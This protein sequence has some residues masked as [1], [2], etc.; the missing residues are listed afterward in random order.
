MNEPLFIQH[1][2]M[3][4]GMRSSSFQGWTL[5]TTF[6]VF[7]TPEHLKSQN[8][9]FFLSSYFFLGIWWARGYVSIFYTSNVWLPASL[10][11]IKA[12]DK[13]EALPCH[14]TE[15]HKNHWNKK[16]DKDTDPGAGEGE[17]WGH[18]VNMLPFW[19]RSAPWW[20]SVPWDFKKINK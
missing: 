8:C 9:K 17:H 2:I 13:A 15:C 3:A 14:A 10:P 5:N 20:W 4:A 12:Q 1:Y 18:E 19:A 6:S 7:R 16:L 11:S